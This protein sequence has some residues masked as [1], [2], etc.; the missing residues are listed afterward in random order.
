MAHDWL[1]FWRSRIGWCGFGAGQPPEHSRVV[2]V[3]LLRERHYNPQIAICNRFSP[4][5]AK[6]AA[7]G[8]LSKQLGVR[9]RAAVC[10]CGMGSPNRQA[11][12]ALTP[13]TAVETD[14][15]VSSL[16]KRLDDCDLQFSPH[17][18]P[19]FLYIPALTGVRTWP[20][21]CFPAALHKS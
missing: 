4:D 16:G 10:M 14:G 7:P 6:R 1:S 2:E 9:Q 21:R 18:T 13:F 19:D 11:H 8:H 20:A 15:R 12:R 17:Y 5:A 3:K